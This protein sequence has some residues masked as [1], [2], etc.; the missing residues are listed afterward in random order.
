MSL[1]NALFEESYTYS[2]T[3][4]FE[5]GKE[6]KST[7]NLA[8]FQIM[9]RVLKIELS[10]I[11]LIFDFNKQNRNHFTTLPPRQV[12]VLT[13]FTAAFEIDYFL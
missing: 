1:K 7:V 3:E 5:V 12:F 9:L 8:V 6:K 13:F 11:K 10:F 2:P 4:S